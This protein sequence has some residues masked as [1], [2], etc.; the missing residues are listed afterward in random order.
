MK[1]C[2]SFYGRAK[3]KEYW[4]VA[5]FLFI[6]GVFLNILGISLL[7]LAP[8]TLLLFPILLIAIW[9]SLA[10]T[11]RR[12]RDAGINLW[13]MLLLLVPFVGFIAWIVFG[14]LPSKKKA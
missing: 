8:L 9:L 11:A 7:V 12:L 5:I 3:R 1:K 14:C 4:G 10:I 2:F 6:L 13:F